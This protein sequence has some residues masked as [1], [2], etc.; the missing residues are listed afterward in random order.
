MAPRGRGKEATPRYITEVRELT[1]T[2]LERLVEPR[3]PSHGSLG[4]KQARNSHHR[5]AMLAAMGL[6]NTQI[7]ERT[8]RQPASIGYLLKAPAMVS[9]VEG[10]RREVTNRALDSVDE[11]FSL[12]TSNMLAAERHLSDRIAELDEADELLSVK[13]ALA[14]SRDAAD[15]FGYG[16]NKTQVN[17]NADFASLLEAAIRRSGKSE[18][19]GNVIDLSATN[20]ATVSSPVAQLEAPAEPS[21]ELL[22]SEPLPFRR[23]V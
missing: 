13:D 16:K 7:A 22:P 1:P 14:I 12:A 11:Y 17:V 15:R 6:N 10:Y 4:V 2:D 5:V 21:A 9:L 20:N 8:G 18:A 23:R 19:V 3:H